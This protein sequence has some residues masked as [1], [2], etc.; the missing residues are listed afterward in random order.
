MSVLLNSRENVQIY[1]L[2]KIQP[3]FSLVENR[4]ARFHELSQTIISAVKKTKGT[5]S[6]DKSLT[7]LF[8]QSGNLG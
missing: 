2:L 5:K 1:I 7:N 4:V 8:M 3:V 6:I